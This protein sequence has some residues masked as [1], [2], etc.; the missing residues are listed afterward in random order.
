MKKEESIGTKEKMIKSCKLF[1][2]VILVLEILMIIGA[3]LLVIVGISI[4]IAIAGAEVNEN[5][6]I[7]ENNLEENANEIISETEE[8]VTSEN[9]Y[10]NENDALDSIRTVIRFIASIVIIDMIRRI[11]KNTAKDETPFSKGNL[12]KIEVIDICMF[13]CWICKIELITIEIIYLLL[14]NCIYLIFK[15][16]YE[17]QIESDETL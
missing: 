14:I 17:L 4:G 7:I 6:Y 2:N 13:I 16:G 15:Y 12:K 3:V 11:L 5:E 1:S 10:I 8:I 9:L